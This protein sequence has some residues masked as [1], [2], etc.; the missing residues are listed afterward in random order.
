MPRSTQNAQPEQPETGANLEDLLQQANKDLYAA[1]KRIAQLVAENEELK[2]RLKSQGMGSIEGYLVKTPW[3]GY[4]GVSLG[5]QFRNGQAFVPME[6]ENKVKQMVDDF[7]YY[8]ERTTFGKME[9]SI[10]EAAKTSLIDAVML[11]E[12]R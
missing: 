10:A 7:S 3:S 2:E 9:S 6:Y 1:D 4:T 12:V 8:A 11:P 5:I